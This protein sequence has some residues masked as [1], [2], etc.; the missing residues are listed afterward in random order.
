MQTEKLAPGDTIIELDSHHG[1]SW[2][3]GFVEAGL[4]PRA[5]DQTADLVVDVHSLAHESDLQAPLA[6]HAARL[7]PGGRLVLNSTTSCPW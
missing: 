2:L 1:G 4:T 7:A 3:G 5:P 6:A